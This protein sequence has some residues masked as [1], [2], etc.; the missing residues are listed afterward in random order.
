MM[1]RRTLKFLVGKFG[2]LVGHFF[3]WWGMCPTS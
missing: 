1:K 3:Q 2:T